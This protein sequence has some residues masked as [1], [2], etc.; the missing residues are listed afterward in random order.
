MPTVVGVIENQEKAEQVI[1]ALVANGIDRDSIGLMWRDRNVQQ[2]EEIRVASYHDHHEDASS[3][4]GKG[5]VGGAIGGATTGAGT[6]LL[7]AGGLALI[8]GIGAFLAAG[9]LAATAGA[10]AAGAIGGGVTGGLLGALIG[11]TD[12]D[13]T[14]EVETTTR[15]REAIEREGYLISV[16]AHDTAE[17]SEVTDIMETV[18][19]TDVSI[20]S[21]RIS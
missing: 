3:E 20:L 1:P 8:P 16:D 21:D 18:G 11:A 5:A 15:Y 12:D 17:A 10:A 6:M 19:V 7:A 2:P 9:T 14:K 13:A 4:A